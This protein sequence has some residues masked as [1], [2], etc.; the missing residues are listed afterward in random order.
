M[1]TMLAKRGGLLFSGRSDGD[2]Q[3]VS[4]DTRTA[5]DR[6]AHTLVGYCFRALG[7]IFD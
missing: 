1:A 3:Y 6:I 4:S 5:S 2:T 7:G